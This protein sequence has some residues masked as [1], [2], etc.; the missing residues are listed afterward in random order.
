MPKNSVPAI[1]HLPEEG[2]RFLAQ[3][4]KHNDRD[5]FNPRKEQYKEL[6]EQPMIQLVHAVSEE[7]RRRGLPLHAKDK[8]PVLR[9]YRD[10]RFS[11]DKTPYKTHVAAA[12]QRSF[13][14]SSVVLYLHFSPSESLVAA[15]VWQ[16]ERTLLQLWRE[17]IAGQP[18]RFRAVVA[19]LEK[20]KLS[21]SMEH[22]L[23]VMPRGFQTYANESFAPWL[24][25]TSF[26]TSLPLLAKDATQPGLL[27]RIIDFALAVKPLLEFGW[28]LEKPEGERITNR[29]A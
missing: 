19:A 28:S 7:C 8:N 9:I 12:L 23:S 25:L 18:Q 13:S 26:I 15:G 20:K 6:V 21:L 17:A 22:S 16:P 4:K 5:W 24:K 27:D 10:I 3:L 14:N 1:D 11:S 2:F 29:L